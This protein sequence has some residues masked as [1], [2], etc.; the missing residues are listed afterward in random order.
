MFAQAARR[1]E[2][3]NLTF[4]RGTIELE[5]SRRLKKLVNLVA[6]HKKQSSSRTGDSERVSEAFREEILSARAKKP[7]QEAQFVPVLDP[8]IE[9]EEAIE[10]PTTDLHD[11]LLDQ[12]IRSSYVSDPD[13][14]V[15]EDLEVS[16]MV[17]AVV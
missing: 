9:V 14:L 6:E 4:A 10:T 1:R 11:V 3:R 8:E 2:V 16:L 5:R 13:S 12:I 17:L 7:G 15:G